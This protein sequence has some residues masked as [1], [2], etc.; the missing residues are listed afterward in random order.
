MSPPHRLLTTNQ[1]CEILGVC[2]TALRALRRRDEFPAG[3]EIGR[4]VSCRV[5]DVDR[6]DGDPA[7]KGLP[8]SGGVSRSSTGPTSRWVTDAILS[9]A[10][11]PARPSSSRPPIASTPTASSPPSSASSPAGPR[12]RI[13]GWTTA[14]NS[15]PQPCGTGA[16]SGAPTPPTEQETMTLILRV[17]SV[18]D[19]S[20]PKRCWPWC[21]TRDLSACC[22]PGTRTDRSGGCD[23]IGALSQAP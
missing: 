12:R 2:R 23:L 18:G 16:A 4:Y 22:W 1:V 21:L 11:S 9:R 19:R 6:A 14:P 5:S 15:S 8:S 17:S 7:D 13:C 10:S 20:D 3:N